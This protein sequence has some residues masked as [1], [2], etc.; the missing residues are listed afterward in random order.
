MTTLAA[1]K[2]WIT[3]ARTAFNESKDPEARAKHSQLWARR[4][5]DALRKF[6]KEEVIGN[7][8]LPGEVQE[9]VDNLG[10]QDKEDI[11]TRSV[12][13][14]DRKRNGDGDGEGSRKPRT[15]R[16]QPTN[17]ILYGPPGT[18]KTYATAERA[19][20]ICDGAVPPG[21]R[22]AVMTRYRE[23]VARR[24]IAFVTFHQSYSYEDFVEG[25]RPETGSSEGEALTG[26]FSLQPRPGVFLQIAS[27]ARDN[28]GRAISPPK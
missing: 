11:R 28:H 1:H 17:L 2:S 5:N 9:I 16:M 14:L 4:I 19:V 7:Q 20:Q 18:G 25:L 15:N 13:D 8:S 3:K 27:L 10:T 22:A 12:G 26:G 24:R 23:L 21:G 6:S